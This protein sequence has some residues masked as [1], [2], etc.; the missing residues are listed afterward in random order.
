[1]SDIEIFRYLSVS[2]VSIMNWNAS[3]LESR[4]KDR[5]EISGA[6]AP[7]R[8]PNYRSGFDVLHGARLSDL[9]VLVTGFRNCQ[10]SFKRLPAYQSETPDGHHH[11]NGFAP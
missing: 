11:A 1:M 6:A 3:T 10:G 5:V 2:P 7:H 9:V 8:C 4:K